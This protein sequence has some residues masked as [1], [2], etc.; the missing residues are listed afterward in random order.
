MSR[1]GLALTLGS[2]VEMYRKDWEQRVQDAIKRN[3]I[4]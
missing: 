2:L 3:P 1:V 4:D